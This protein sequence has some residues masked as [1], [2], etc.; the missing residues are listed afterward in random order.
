MNKSQNLRDS[1]FPVFIIGSPGSGTSILALAI[2]ST[3]KI[4]F[5]A[6][7]HF[8]PLTNYIVSSIDDYY[9]IKSSFIKIERR[10][11]ARIKQDG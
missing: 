9:E 7:G 3:M 8:L 5:Y 4:P 1:E 10:A 6:E 11:I 2:R